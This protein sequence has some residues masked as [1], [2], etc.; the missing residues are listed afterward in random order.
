MKKRPE[1]HDSLR[2]TI[3]N[4]EERS[5]ELNKEIKKMEIVLVDTRDIYELSI[6]PSKEMHN[7]ISYSKEKLL[8]LAENIKSIKEENSGLLGTGL[9][10]PIM[11]REKKG[12]YE[13][14]H[15]NN[16]I[17]AVEFNG[18]SKVPCV[19]LKNVSD[20][21][22]RFMRTSENLKREDLNA[23]DETLSILEHLQMSC[24]FESIADVKSLL[25]S[26]KNYNSGKIKL[27]EKQINQRIEVNSI[28]DR[29]GRFNINTLC[30]RLVVL[31]LNPIIIQ[32]LV[33]ERIGYTQA[34]TINTVLKN[35]NELINQ[36]L[37]FLDNNTLTVGKLK[38]YV[39]K[40]KFP[41]KSETRKEKSSLD[42]LNTARS[43]LNKKTYQKLSSE[44]KELVDRKLELVEKLFKEIKEEIN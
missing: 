22:A 1:R 41:S 24:G 6:S 42:V 19:I 34:T 16:R 30:D 40:L 5:K 14:I 12:R 23:Y 7:R 2:D 17:K 26:V 21:L 31:N 43:L 44:K 15:G 9:L 18:D 32:A 10:N 13:R 20:E 35:D 38:E 25:N 11:L 27:T 39:T 4:F 28:L 29:I 3:T 8:E 37:D 36:A 33:D